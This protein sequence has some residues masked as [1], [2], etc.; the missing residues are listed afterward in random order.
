[1]FSPRV[2]HERAV[3][4]RYLG[5]RVA[6]R[7]SFLGAYA[8]L[9]RLAQ[10]PLKHNAASPDRIVGGTRD[11]V[12]EGPTARDWLAAGQ[13]RGGRQASP[14]FFPTALDY[15]FPVSGAVSSH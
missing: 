11:G 4:R 15:V 10:L 14:L 9:G 8:I 5:K 1:M 6:G 7:D 13:S 3:L 2:V 12:S